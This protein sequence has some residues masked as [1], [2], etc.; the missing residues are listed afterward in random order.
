M[1]EVSAPLLGASDRV[2]RRGRGAQN[3]APPLRGSGAC[4]PRP[5]PGDLP[6]GSQVDGTRPARDAAVDIAKRSALVPAAA[7][8]AGECSDSAVAAG[9]QPSPMHRVVRV[10]ASNHKVSADQWPM[11]GHCGRFSAFSLGMVRTGCAVTSADRVTSEDAGP[12]PGSMSAG[13]PPLRRGAEGRSGSRF[14]IGATAAGP[15]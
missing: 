3:L 8:R 1:G 15:G 9:T 11:I 2:R 4:A 12:E 10:K 5:R 14:A 13:V 6:L 7:R